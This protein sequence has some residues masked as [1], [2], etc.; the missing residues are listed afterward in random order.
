MSKNIKLWVSTLRS[1][2]FQQGRQGLRLSQEQFCCLGVACELYRQSTGK[3]QWENKPGGIYWFVL[4]GLDHTG[5]LPNPVRAWLGIDDP[6]IER[7]L[8]ALNDGGHSFEDIAN[9]IEKTLLST[10]T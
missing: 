9:Y 10:K 1:D 3:G 5:F 8:A 4:D 6:R 7:T 2:A